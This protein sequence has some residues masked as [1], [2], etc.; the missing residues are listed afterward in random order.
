MSIV[1]RLLCG[2]RA[3]TVLATAAA[4]APLFAQ[5]EVTLPP[6]GTPSAGTQDQ[7]VYVTARR[8]EERLSDVPVSIT[9]FSQEAIQRL[10]AVD[11]SGVQGAVPNLNLVQGRGSSS[12]ANIFIRGVGQPDALQTFDPAVGIYVDGVYFSRI[13]GALLNLFDV[14]RL[15]VLRGPQGTLYGKNTIGG[16][17]NLISRRPDLNELR[18]E[19]A[20]TYGSYDQVVAN[21]YVSLP[22]AADVA[23]LSVA[24]ILDRRDGLVTDPVT[25]RE[26][27]DRDTIGGRALL[28][29]RP[30]S[31]LELLFSGDY[32]RVDTALT[33]GR[34]EAP[35]CQLA[36]GLP[37]AA[38]NLACVPPRGFFG[39][40]VLVPAP[41][42]QY[43]FS[44]ATSFTGDEGQ[45]LEHWGLSLNASWNLS[46]ALTLVSITAYRELQPRFFI[47]IDATRTETGDVFVGVDQQQF[48]QELQ[49]RWESDRFDGVF[50][51]YYLD[52]D[53][54]ST[55]SAF[56]DDVFSI[57]GILPVTFTRTVEDDQNTRS[58]A[59]FGQLVWQATDRLSVT[60][61]LRYTRDRKRYFRTTSTFSN[62]A[63]FRSSFTFPDSLIG[64]PL[65]VGIDLTDIDRETWDAWT[66]QV[67]ISYKPDAESLLWI[68]AARGFKSGGF[69]GRANSITDLL[70]TVDG[71]RVLAVTFDPETVWTYEAGYRSS[72]LNGLVDLSASVFYSDY[73]NFQARVG[74]IDAAGF[75]TLPVINAGKLR[76]WG[77]EV[78]GHARPAAGLVLTGALGYLNAEYKEFDDI[79]ANGCNVA[80]EIVCEPAF[81]PPITARLA[82]D[83]SFSVGAGSVTFG[84]E[85]RFVDSQFLSVDNRRPALFENGY[86]L[87]NAYVQYDSPGRSWYLRGGVKNLTDEVYRT[88]A[89]EFSS[90]SNVQ[91]AYYGDPRTWSV[92][93]GLRF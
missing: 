42:G 69:N 18:G 61:G 14:E 9:A 49:L 76:L 89:Q 25:G 81:A 74:D 23:A 35:I 36:I 29:V 34:N 77:I 66:P 71:Q 11:L 7:V 13:Q 22:L 75:G 73:R 15:E 16:A 31:E 82:A 52:E 6:A 59:A 45:E 44:G 50:G 87:V 62:Q 30:S 86:A 39:N 78:E 21:G 20:A 88:D 28:R 48:S 37:A 79:R 85:T 47:D 51:L 38:A 84:G 80:G 46:D 54:A 93:A 12:S 43:D 65:L 8:R 17:I 70:Q 1:S 57:A 40:R 91:T 4:A 56:A 92:T 27:N 90:V 53:L 3:G 2:L 26:Y 24:A 72:W 41:T 33:L 63:A 67:S 68:S 10:Q 19:V 55:Q 58:F 5:D 32:T 64:N 60:G 83:Y